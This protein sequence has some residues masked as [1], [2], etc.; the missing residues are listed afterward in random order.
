MISPIF[1]GHGSPM[2]AH[3]GYRLVRNF[4][5]S[6][7]R[8]F[9]RKLS[10][11]SLRIGKRKYS[12]FHPRMTFMRRSMISAAFPMSCFK[13]NILPKGTSRWLKR[14]LTF[15]A[16]GIP[17]AARFTRGLDHGSWV[18]LFR[19]FPYTG[20]PGHSSVR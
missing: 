6:M 5:S 9:H 4:C 15:P 2:M 3:S 1:V 13:S 11:F 10:S 20:M 14:S 18:P 16:K 17:V 7:G 19:M 12:P 8:S